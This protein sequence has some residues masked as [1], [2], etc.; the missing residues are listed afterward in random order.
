[1]S[2]LVT[3]NGKMYKKVPCY[4]PDGTIESYCL[5]EVPAGPNVPPA[6]LFTECSL[7]NNVSVPE[8]IAIEATRE[9]PITVGETDVPF[10]N[11]DTMN[12]SEEPVFE[13]ELTLENLEVRQ[14]TIEDNDVV[15]DVF[16]DDARSSACSSSI[17]QTETE[18]LDSEH[19]DVKQSKRKDRM[20]VMYSKLDAFDFD[21]EL[22]TSDGQYLI[23]VDGIYVFGLSDIK[24]FLGDN[25]VHWLHFRDTPNKVNRAESKE[26]CYKPLYKTLKNI[27]VRSGPGSKFGATAVVKAHEQIIVL[28]EGLLQCDLEL[29]REWMCLHLPANLYYDFGS[30]SAPTLEDFIDEKWEVYHNDDLLMFFA[31]KIYRFDEAKVAIFRK[32]VAA[33]S[34]KVKIVYFEN[35]EEKTGWIS[36][37]KNSGALISRVYG[38][39]APKVVISGVRTQ[40]RKSDLEI[41]DQKRFEGTFVPDAMNFFDEHTKT[42]SIKYYNEKGEAKEN[43]ETHHCRPTMAFFKN[44][45]KSEISQII[46]SKK[47]R[48]TIDWQSKFRRD[49][50][51]GLEKETVVVDGKNRMR[52]GYHVPSEDIIVTFQ[53]KKDARAFVDADLVGTRFSKT[54]ID[55][56]ASYENLHPVNAALC[57]EYRVYMAGARRSEVGISLIT[58]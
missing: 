29:V 13:A 7:V 16:D 28:Q 57:P 24:K 38:N 40:F 10:E 23:N 54:C 20:H 35:G 32:A 17:D 31:Q 41:E 48:F 9:T 53:T 56:E 18:D 50:F 25:I 30:S 27:Q 51:R 22:R 33:A 26:V 44:L 55:W 14:K 52:T 6:S 12:V 11:E 42:T 15:G 4:F 2:D 34:R 45:A 8:P 36:K 58:V 1:M 37:R 19:E 47:S 21:N 43:T 49:R 39:S 5:V 3:R 46:G